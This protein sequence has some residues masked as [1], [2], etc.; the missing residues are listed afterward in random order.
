MQ[1]SCDMSCDIGVVVI[2]G[3]DIFNVAPY[4]LQGYFPFK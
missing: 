4:N 1:E 2:F 3:A